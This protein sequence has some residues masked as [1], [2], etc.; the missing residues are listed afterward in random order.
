[1]KLKF[2]QWEFDFDTDDA[3][4]VVPLILLLLGVFFTPL[5]REWLLAGGAAYYLLIFFLP[6]LA[7]MVMKAVTGAL[8][9]QRNRCPYCKSHEIILQGMAEFRGDVPYDWYLCNS[10]RQTSIFVFDRMIKANSEPRQVP[11]R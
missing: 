4:I 10:C 8:K 7:L 6:K 3:R 9:R 1:M 5:R 11:N 2:W